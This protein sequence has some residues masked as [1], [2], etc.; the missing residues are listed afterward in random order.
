MPLSPPQK[1][2]QNENHKTM[3]KKNIHRSICDS[4]HYIL[5]QIDNNSP[6][7]KTM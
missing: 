6:Q 4:R 1:K 5:D 3:Q 2:N 7:A